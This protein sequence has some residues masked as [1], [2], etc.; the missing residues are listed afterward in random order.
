MGDRLTQRLQPSP[1]AGLP[2]PLVAIDFEASSLDLRGYPIEVGLALWPAPDQPIFGWST[3]IRPGEDWTRNGHW[4]PASAKVHG[5]RGGEL[6]ARGKSPRRVAS[7]LNQALGAGGVAWCDGGPYDTHWARALFKAGA[8]RPLFTF[9]DW[10]QLASMLGGAARERA[11][12]GLEREPALHR[13]RADAEQ[14]LLALAGAAGIEVGPVQDLDQQL[15][16]LAALC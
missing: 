13:A 5:I 12:T 14:L 9:G 1:L 8:T 2:W 4:S 3:L 10:H 11:L 16:A 7:A 15:P 6:L